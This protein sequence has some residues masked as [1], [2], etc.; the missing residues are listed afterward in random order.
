VIVDF[1]KFQIRMIRPESKRFGNFCIHIN[2]TQLIRVFADSV[3]NILL[4]PFH[5][6][7]PFVENHRWRSWTFP[8]S[9]SAHNFYTTTIS[10]RWKLKLI[11]KY[12][13]EDTFDFEWRN[14][15][16]FLNESVN[17]TVRDRTKTNEQSLKWFTICPRLSVFVCNYSN[18]SKNNGPILFYFLAN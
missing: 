2:S 11:Q 10:R 5:P 12:S 4:V 8:N 18:H 17:L 6:I 13:A 9:L 1:N 14:A 3:C 15:L 7:Y 16:T